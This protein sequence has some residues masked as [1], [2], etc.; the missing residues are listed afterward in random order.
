MP[1]RSDASQILP[2]P[3]RVPEESEVRVLGP[4]PVSSRVPAFDPRRQRIQRFALGIVAGCGIVCLVA[5]LK[6]A[7]GG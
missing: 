2:P 6:A 3:V 7:L 5:I 4:R 1:S